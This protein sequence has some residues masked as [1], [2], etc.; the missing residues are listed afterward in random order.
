[1]LDKMT[2]PPEKNLG[3]PIRNIGDI[4]DL[5][6]LKTLRQDILRSPYHLCTQKA[7]LMTAYFRKKKRPGAA[8]GLLSAIHF[9]QFK[10]TLKKARRDK[11]Q[12]PWQIKLGNFLN[13]LYL[14]LDGTDQCDN[15]IDFSFALHYVL[16]HMPLT[17]Y[18]HE[19][20][21]GNSSAF[22]VGAPI[23]PDLG[24]L[25]MLPEINGLKSRPLNP[26][27]TD[28]EQV[29]ELHEDIFPF[30]FNRSVM[31]RAPLYGKDP[32]MFNTLLEGSYY[33]LT[34][35][36]GI[37]HVTPDYPTVLKLGF[38]GIQKTAEKKLEQALDRTGRIGKPDKK[39]SASQQIAFYRS[40]IIVADAAIEYGKRWKT[41]LVKLA[42]DTSHPVRR[43]E[44]E[45]LAQMFTN[46]PANPP[47]SFH[48]A[49]QMVFITHVILHQENFQHGVSFGRMDQ[50]LYP[51][52]VNDIRSG[53]LTPERATEI[54]GCFICK[55]GELLPLFFD[56]A[57]EYF[58]GLSS[59]S[60]ITL[61]GVRPDGTSGVNDLSYLILLA[62]DQVRLRQPNFHV[63]IDRDTP[64]PFK[65]LCY[66]VLKK[67]GGIPAFFN[68]S[69]IIPALQEAGI[70]VQDATDYAIVGCVEWGIPG[71]SFPAAGAVFVNL[72][73]ALHLAL[74]DGRI[75]GRQFGPRTGAL[76]NLTSMR[77]LLDAFQKQLVNLLA[78]AVQGNNAIETTHARHRPTPFL[79]IIVDGCIENGMEI[80]A[81]GARYNSTG[82]QGVGL[83]DVIDSF[84]AIDHLVFQERKLSLVDFIAA[85]DDDFAKHHDLR[86]YILNKIPKYGEN[87]EASDGYGRVISGL[88]TEAVMTFTNPR[89]G[90]YFPGFWTMTTHMGFGNRMPALPSGRRAGEALANGVSACNGRDRK[91]PTAALAS[92]SRL[93][94][95]RVTN[96]YA[97]NQKLSSGYLK[98]ISGNQLLEGIISGYFKQSGMQL[99]FNITDHTILAEAKAHPEK[100]PDLVVRVSGY[101]AYFNDLTEAMKEELINRTL[102]GTAEGT[103]CA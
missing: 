76:N 98:G 13:R 101:S 91:G 59:A 14:K 53:V 54:M 86:T 64:T 32:N 11:P 63:R 1:M 51:Y 2:R 100:Y 50:Y 24:G 103:C 30:W 88:Y 65:S 8:L 17:V 21:V 12:S 29:R 57:T 61:G 48:E 69:T 33:I 60:G 41:E 79:S 93:D 90:S 72:A 18:D 23:H 97:L 75:H 82:C 31:A 39:D 7:S 89:R 70:A 83:A 52:Y 67:G 38:K 56:R 71:K 10:K 58:S 95:G 19:L 73:M 36:S 35:F 55:A 84:A 78:L 43:A 9:K 34:Q 102:H 99:Q 46:I 77:M 40:A 87:A 80:N 96:G 6:R 62:Y 25:M 16:R 66:E 27:Q 26:I 81:G 22:R 49:V 37:S 47:R 85:V 3:R 20:I 28:P 68:D 15:L 5:P 92:A 42:D 4:P 44:L 45:E 74:H 94:T